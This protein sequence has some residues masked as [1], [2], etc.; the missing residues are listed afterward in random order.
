MAA[1]NKCLA[2]SN[3]SG[4]GGE[5][6]K[7]RDAA[8]RAR[9]QHRQEGQARAL[10]MAPMTEHDMIGWF[11]AA[12]MGS[13][14]QRMLWAAHKIARLT[15]ATEDNVYQTLERSLERAGPP[16]SGSSV[17]RQRRVA[18]GRLGSLAISRARQDKLPTDRRRNASGRRVDESSD[19]ADGRP[20]IKTRDR[21]LKRL[22]A[23]HGEPR[24][25]LFNSRR[26]T[27]S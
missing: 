26:A 24:F 4:T 7:K 21:L 11:N 14:Q 25:D 5:A 19:G 6:T 18:L 8:H 16:P 27:C 2:Q 23:V 12:P 17:Q 15:G 13:R 10:P 3:K 1:T 9:P 22:I 20:T